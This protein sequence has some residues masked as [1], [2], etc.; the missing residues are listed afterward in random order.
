MH[1]ITLNMH[2]MVPL[3][4]VPH[5]NTTKN[6]QINKRAADEKFKD[7]QSRRCSLYF[8]FPLPNA[9]SIEIFYVNHMN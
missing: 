3:Q 7:Y 9:N 4:M 6:F 1:R 2:K 5:K 8:H